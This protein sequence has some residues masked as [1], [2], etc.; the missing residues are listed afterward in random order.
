MCNLKRVCNDAIGNFFGTNA[1]GN[2]LCCNCLSDMYKVI[3]YKNVSVNCA[4]F[5]AIILSWHI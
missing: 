2:L 3:L 1:N 5:P 4:H